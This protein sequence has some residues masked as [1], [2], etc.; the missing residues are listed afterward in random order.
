MGL[1]F[2]LGILLS[3]QGQEEERI[4]QR[5]PPL[6]NR[7]SAAVLGCFIAALLSKP[8]AMSFSLVLLL[9]DWYP[10]NR[11]RLREQSGESPLKKR[12]CCC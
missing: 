1:F 9:L 10:L 12:P 11:F 4:T 3:L 2:F 7:H 6:L 8:M 5:R